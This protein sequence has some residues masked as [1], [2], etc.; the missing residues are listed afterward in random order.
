MV[1][2][3]YAIGVFR[4]FF[5]LFYFVC[6]IWNSLVEKRLLYGNISKSFFFFFCFNLFI[7]LYLL[8]GIFYFVLFYF[9]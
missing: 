9:T 2:G 7:L 3:R 4:D 6:I 5:I 8:Y 1:E